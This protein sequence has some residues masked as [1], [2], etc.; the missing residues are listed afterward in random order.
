MISVSSSDNFG[1][2]GKETD[3][4][5]KFNAFGNNDLSS[6]NSQSS[7]GIVAVIPAFAKSEIIFRGCFVFI[8]AR[9]LTDN[10]FCLFSEG[11]S[12]KSNPDFL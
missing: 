8:M 4:C 9:Y 1:Y 10:R 6:N 3:F 2:I 12:S 11:K 7:I 5:I